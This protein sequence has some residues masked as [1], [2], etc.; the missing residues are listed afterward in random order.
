MLVTSLG[1]A[2]QV[3]AYNS[4]LKFSQK[5]PIMLKRLAYAQLSTYYSHYIISNTLQRETENAISLSAT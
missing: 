2:A 5:L 4:I 3:S 1:S